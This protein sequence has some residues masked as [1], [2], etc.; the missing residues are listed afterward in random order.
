M[1]ELDKYEAEELARLIKD[2]RNRASYL[3]REIKGTEI[4]PEEIID[5]AEDLKNAVYEFEL[6]VQTIENGERLDEQE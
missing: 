4:P 6:A 5:M 1:N 3:Y 2:I